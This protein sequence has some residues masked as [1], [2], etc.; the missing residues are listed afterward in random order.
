MNIARHAR[1][2]LEDL[3]SPHLS[4]PVGS[5]H[6]LRDA[7]FVL[8]LVFGLALLLFVLAWLLR[9]RWG[10]SSR[11]AHGALA[12]RSSRPHGRELHRRRRRRRRSHSNPT[13]A[14]VGGLPPR[15]DQLVS[16]DEGRS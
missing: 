12:F 11:E 1:L 16:P 15:R 10:R 14:E 7:G 3:W 13:R 8:A 2:E 9:N 5:A 6:A 4:E